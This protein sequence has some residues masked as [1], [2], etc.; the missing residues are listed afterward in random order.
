MYGLFSSDDSN[1]REEAKLSRRASSF[2]VGS[3]KGSLVAVRFL[4]RKNIELT[5][6]V[7]RELHLLKEMTCDNINRFHGACIDLPTICIVTQYCARGSLK[8]SATIIHTLYQTR[9]PDHGDPDIFGN[10][11]Y[12]FSVSLFCLLCGTIAMYR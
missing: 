4:K 9:V 12:G 10:I 6:I 3:Y 2:R 7:K 5:K 1:A 8:V 11:M